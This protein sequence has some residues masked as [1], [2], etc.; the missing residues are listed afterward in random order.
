[1]GKLDGKNKRLPLLVCH[2]TVCDEVIDGILV[3][4]MQHECYVSKE[5]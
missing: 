5:T 3:L 1:L 2:A 4:Y